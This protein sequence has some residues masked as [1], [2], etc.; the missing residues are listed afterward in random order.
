MEKMGFIHHE[1]FWPKLKKNTIYHY[2][3]ISIVADVGWLAF[4]AMEL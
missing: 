4:K 2:F 3:L 1:V